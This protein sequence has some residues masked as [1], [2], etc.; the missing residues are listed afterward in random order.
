[1]K[2]GCSAEVQKPAQLK[3]DIFHEAVAGS[4]IHAPNS[5]QCFCVSGNNLKE[6]KALASPVEKKS[7]KDY[8]RI[9]INGITTLLSIVSCKLQL[10]YIHESMVAT[11]TQVKLSLYSVTYTL[12]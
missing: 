7:L 11:A 4:Q 6:T 3:Q 12:F 5:C 1:M 10:Q 2:A 8:M 9:L